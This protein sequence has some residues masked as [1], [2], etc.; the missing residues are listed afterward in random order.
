MLINHR[1]LVATDSSSQGDLEKVFASCDQVIERT[2]HTRANQ[3]AMMET[4]ER[5]V[6]S[7]LMEDFM[8]FLPL[9]LFSIVEEFL[10]TH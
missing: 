1:N 2:Y 10:L 3:Q 7:I 5:I 9:K 8:L 6:K 4:L